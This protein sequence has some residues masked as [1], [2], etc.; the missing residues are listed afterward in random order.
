MSFGNRA[1]DALI[2]MANGKSAEEDE[3]HPE[4][5]PL[6][7]IKVLGEW[8]AEKA[9]SALLSILFDPSRENDVFLERVKDA[10]VEIG[11]PVL[12][13]ALELIEAAGAFGEPHEYLLMVLAAVG[14]TNKSD[15]VFR[16]LK[17]LFLRMDNKLLGASCLGEY[18]DGRAIPALRGF[19]EKNLKQLDRETFFEINSAVR[20]LGGS[21]EDITR[22]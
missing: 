10:L 18:G 8:K 4:L 12:E 1:V 7:A 16:C 9:V 20:K 19:V 15:R 5:V 11:S 21:M 6:A 2:E 13:P 3:R 14:S 22:R 17:S